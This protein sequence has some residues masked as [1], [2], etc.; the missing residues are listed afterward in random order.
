MKLN[1]K[2]AGQGEPILILHGIFGSLDN[3]QTIA[4]S[5]SEKFM[6]VIADLRNHGKSPHSDEFSIALM[7]DDVIELMDDLGIQ[8]TILI[9]HSLG[10]KIA[11]QLAADHSDRLNKLIVV[12]MAPKIYPRGHDEILVA[13]R[14]IDFNELKSRNEID[15][16][17]AERIPDV[18]VRQFLMK[19]LARDESGSYQWKFNLNSL[20]KNYDQ[21][22]PPP[23]FNS[24][25]KIPTLFIRGEKSKY[26]LEG[27]FETIRK[28][29]ADWW[30]ETIAGAGH[31]VHSE[32]PKEFIDAVKNFIS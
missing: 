26:I 1:Y 29:F 2:I 7:V 24:I 25:V 20:E 21:I 17:L 13:L 30:L 19:S 5:L 14:S 31:W 32:K 4:N 6:V 18:S 12:D 27:D 3:W 15:E 11:M 8:K 16:K 9:G 10:G 22:L 23:V 28:H